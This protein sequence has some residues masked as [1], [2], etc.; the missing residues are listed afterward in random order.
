VGEPAIPGRI[1]HPGL[2]DAK[3]VGYLVSLQ[4]S[5]VAHAARFASFGFGRGYRCH[6][7]AVALKPP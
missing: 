5:V 4:K 1:A 7:S 6:A 3:Q 2:G